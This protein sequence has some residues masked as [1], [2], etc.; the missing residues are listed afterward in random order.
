VPNLSVAK[1]AGRWWFGLLVLSLTGCG[2]SQVAQAPPSGVPE[3][4]PPVVVSA[5]AVDAFLTGRIASAA[6]DLEAAAAAFER[7]V[8]LEPTDPELRMELARAWANQAELDRANLHLQVA[9]DLGVSEWRVAEVRSL[10]L[11]RHGNFDESIDAFASANAE[12]A[13]ESWFRAWFQLASRAGSGD[14]Q[15]LAAE[16]FAQYHP[17]IARPYRLLAIALRDLGDMAG[18]A[19]QFGQA[20]VRSGAEPWDS[21]QRIRLLIEMLDWPAALTATEDCVDR[22][23]DH[24]MCRAVL[25]ELRYQSQEESTAPGESVVQAIDELARMTGGNRGALATAGR[26]LIELAR[27]ELATLYALQIQE[28][29][30]FNVTSL[31]QAAYIVSAVE[32]YDTADALMLR[33]LELDAANFEALNFVGYSWADRG[34]RLEEA[35][36]FIRLALQLRPD[37]VNIEDSLAWVLYRQGRF[38]EALEIQT[39]VVERSNTNAV[40]L[41]H[42]GDIQWMAGLREEAAESWER[43]MGFAD[44]SD[45]DVLES[46]PVKLERLMRGE[47]PLAP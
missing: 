38:P 46:V 42:L 10:A 27:P 29:R 32:D 35:E 9:Y 26:A 47:D 22:F 19:E 16:R 33:V 30:P 45:E 13:P 2:G 14:G 41:D 12:G 6:G 37:D 5:G 11:E 17:D 20:V 23:R 15:I 34:V 44:E 24:V 4:P 21:E 18:S 25:A 1:G 7:A 36:E 39:R 3:Y 31:I 28:Q 40:L 43:A 8:E